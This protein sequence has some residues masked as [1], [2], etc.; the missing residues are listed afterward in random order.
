MPEVRLQV[1]HGI[2]QISCNAMIKPVAVL[3]LDVIVHQG[4]GS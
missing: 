4:S 2:W 1:L 3:H